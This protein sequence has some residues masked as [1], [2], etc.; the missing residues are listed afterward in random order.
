M[1]RFAARA[2]SP[3]NARFSSARR[4][5][6]ARFFA[7]RLKHL[8]LRKARALTLPAATTTAQA[9]TASR[10]MISAASCLSAC[11]PIAS[12]VLVYRSPKRM[13]STSPTLTSVGLPS[14]PLTVMCPVEQ[15]SFATL[16]RLMIWRP[17]G[18]CP[19]ASTSPR[20]GTGFLPDLFP[21]HAS[22]S[23]ETGL[24]R[25]NGPVL[26][27]RGLELAAEALP[28]LN[29]GARSRGSRSS[30]RSRGCAWRAP[31]PDFKRAE[32]HRWTLSPSGPP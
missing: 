30:R 18:T 5:R 20:R 1:S 24:P 2:R 28:A 32:A 26:F 16:L 9:V 10:G 29:A 25:R 17:S 19:A 11:S 12:T 27:P 4:H 15:A 14:F 13:P 3:E 21:A 23:T 31:A 6:R 8:V 7:E 22:S